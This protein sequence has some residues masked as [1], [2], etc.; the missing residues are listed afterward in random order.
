MAESVLQTATAVLKL[1]QEASRIEPADP[2]LVIAGELQ[3]ELL[4]AAAVGDV[5]AERPGRP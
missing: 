2:G 3:Q 4:A 5:Q 1:R